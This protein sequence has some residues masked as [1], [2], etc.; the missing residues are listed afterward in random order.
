MMKPR[1]VR[2]LFIAG[3]LGVALFSGCAL[4]RPPGFTDPDVPT[5]DYMIIPVA[6]DW[7]PVCVCYRDPA[8]NQFIASLWQGEVSAFHPAELVS[9]TSHINDVLKRV[10]ATNHDPNRELSFIRFGGR[11]LL[12]WATK[13]KPEGSK[14]ILRST[15]SVS[16]T[17]KTFSIPMRGLGPSDPVK[18]AFLVLGGV[19]YCFEYPFPDCDVHRFLEGGRM[20][21]EASQPTAEV[22]PAEL[23]SATKTINA[24]LDRAAST[25]RDPK[26]NLCLIGYDDHLFLAWSQHV[27][28]RPE[29]GVDARTGKKAVY[30]ALK[31][32]LE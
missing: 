26:R 13:T 25:N 24:I 27:D 17:A 30:K 21:W 11:F 12:V 15:D 2:F 16:K 18:R 29:G 1:N 8:S 9:A 3:V 22:H 31:L 20:L 14:P 32:R 10:A 28:K 19:M 5:Y 23:I 4:R 6:P 7:H